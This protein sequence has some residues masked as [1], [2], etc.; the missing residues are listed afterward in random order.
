MNQSIPQLPKTRQ[1]LRGISELPTLPTVM[2]RMMEALNTPDL[3]LKKIV[4]IVLEDPAIASKILKL[5]NSSYYGF[6]GEVRSIEHAIVLLGTEAVRSLALGS[7]VFN[8]I[9]CPADVSAVDTAGLWTHFLAVAVCSKEIASRSQIC[10]ADV[11]FTAGLIHDIGVLALLCLYPSE[12]C[13]IMEEAEAGETS[14]LQ[15]EMQAFGLNHQDAGAYLASCWRLPEILQSSIL[16]HHGHESIEK[17]KLEGTIYLADKICRSTHIGWA[18][19][20]TDVEIL[21]D[22]IIRLGASSEQLDEVRC[23]VQEGREFICEFL[24]NIG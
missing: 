23:F 9:R 20:S 1:V 21:P 22:E 12:Y 15:L 4:S 6:Q 17:G 11:A 13:Q 18:F 19:T 8:T 5:A 3:S 16:H 14:F 7:S 10:E 2:Y 24:D